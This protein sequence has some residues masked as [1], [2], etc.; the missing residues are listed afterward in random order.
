MREWLPV[1]QKGGPR[2]EQE[3]GRRAVICRC[4]WR[5][6]SAGRPA[7]AAGRPRPV[8]GPTAVALKWGAA[9]ACP[10]V[11]GGVAALRRAPGEGERGGTG[12]PRRRQE[13]VG[14]SAGLRYSL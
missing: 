6:G 11:P 1:G 10:S 5:G 7:F 13:Q 8:R 4:R 3:T 2:G 12:A 14:R 9:G